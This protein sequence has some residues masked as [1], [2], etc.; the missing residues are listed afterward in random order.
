[1]SYVAVDGVLCFDV[2][3]LVCF[4]CLEVRSVLDLSLGFEGSCDL[5][6]V[7]CDFLLGS[8]DPFVEWCGFEAESR[9]F[10]VTSC[11]PLVEVVPGVKKSSAVIWES[12]DLEHGNMGLWNCVTWSIHTEV[13]SILREC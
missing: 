11:D 13:F 10:T 7:A 9:D 4:G 6:L 3:P 12:W 8:C 2:L 1:M 5:L